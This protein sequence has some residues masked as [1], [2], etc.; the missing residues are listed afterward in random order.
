MRQGCPVKTAPTRRLFA[1]WNERRGTRLAPE[2]GDIEPGAIRDV[3]GNSFI[4]A[5]DPPADHPFRLAGTKVCALF[6]HELKGEP[7]G[8]LWD[9]ASRKMMRETVAI[10]ADEAGAGGPDPSPPTPAWTPHPVGFPQRDRTGRLARGH[11]RRRNQDSCRWRRSAAD[12]S[13]CA[14]I[15]SAATCSRIAASIR[16]KSPT[17]RRAAWP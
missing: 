4:I 2:R 5:F 11:C 10:V 1:Y 9:E 3:L 7:F 15:C 17:C 12:F 8:A 6:R 13:A 14:S 16:A